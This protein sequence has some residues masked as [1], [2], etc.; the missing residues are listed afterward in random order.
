MQTAV[1]CLQAGCLYA[2]K[3]QKAIC[4]VSICFL[5]AD[6]SKCGDRMGDLQRRSGA[7]FSCRSNA[8]GEVSHYDQKIH[9]ICGACVGTGYLLNA[10][11]RQRPGGT[12]AGP[13]GN[14]TFISPFRYPPDRGSTCKRRFMGDD[15]GRPC[16]PFCFRF[17]VFVIALKFFQYGGR[18]NA[19]A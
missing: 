2:P 1:C 14:G 3:Q 6:Q 18:I 7:I 13:S 17:S 16:L 12:C 4:A 11:D 5:P 10:G 19:Q 9:C 15:S 8:D